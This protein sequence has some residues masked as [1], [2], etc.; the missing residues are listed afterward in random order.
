MDSETR[1]EQFK[2]MADADPTNEL[3][4]FSLGKAY[5]ESGRYAEAEPCFARVLELNETYS[6]AYQFLGE[7]RLKL[8]RRDDGIRTL[9]QGYINASERGDVMPRDE[10]AKTLTSLGEPL[11]EVQATSSSDTKDDVANAAG[12]DFKCSRCGKPNAQMAERPFRGALGERILANICEG[13][14]TEWIGMGTKVINEMALP[15][16]DPRAQKIYD[17][18]MTEFLGIE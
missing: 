15:L 1:I 18:Q 5:Y 4:H 13:C 14:W 11:P 6:K 9:R 10:I 17:E 12:G 8:E 3:G 2:K 16:A 7:T